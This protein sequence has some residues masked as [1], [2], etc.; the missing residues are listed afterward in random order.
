MAR[1]NL[2]SILLLAAISYHQCEALSAPTPS[3]NSR[4]DFLQTTVASTI[5]AATTTATGT[6]TSVFPSAVANAAAV[7]ATNAAA[8][9]KLPPIGLGA[10]AWGDSVFWGYNPKVSVP[11]VEM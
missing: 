1:T 7:P 2:L 3:T 6:A 9:L 5:A 11:V 8:E 4:R 10:W